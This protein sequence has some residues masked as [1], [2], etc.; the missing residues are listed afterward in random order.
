[1][2]FALMEVLYSNLVVLGY[3]MRDTKYGAEAVSHGA[4][5]RGLLLPVHFA[6][7]LKLLGSVA[8]SDGR[9]QVLQFRRLVSV[10]VWLIQT[11]GGPAA[12]M[13]GNIDVDRDPPLMVSKQLLS[14]AQVHR[15]TT[16]SLSEIIR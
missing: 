10:A 5:S 6:C 1:V 15:L 8:G 11:I 4:S 7:D 12:A 2:A 14:A 3:P 13:V 9:S 16:F